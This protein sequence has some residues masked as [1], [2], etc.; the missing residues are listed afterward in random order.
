MIKNKKIIKNYNDKD[1]IISVSNSKYDLSDNKGNNKISS[2][3]SNSVMKSGFSIF[4]MFFLLFSVISINFV[5]ADLENE[6][7]IS[8]TLVNQDPDP[9]IAGEIVELRVGIEN[10]GGDKVDDLMIDLDFN[11]PFEEVAGEDYEKVAGTITGYQGN[12]NQK[13]I[14]YKVK[15]NKDTSAGIYDLKIKYY[16]KGSD[17]EFID[18]L[19]VEVGNKEN[20][21]IVS[22][23]KTIL[24]PGKPTDVKFSIKNVG[25]SPIEDV[26]FSFEDEDNVILPVGS[27]NTQ[28]IDYIAVNEVVDVEYTIVSDSNVV[29]GLYKLNLYL[30]YDDSVFGAS[31]SFTTK[32]G[33]YVGGVTDFDVSFSDS[34]AGEMSFTVANIGSNEASSVSVV[35]PDQSGWS[36]SGAKSV[37][38]GNLDKGD[39]TVA[40][41]ALSSSKVAVSAQDADGDNVKTGRRANADFELSEDAK[42]ELRNSLKESNKDSSGLKI[43]I[44]YT[45]T[46]GER[47]TVEKLVDLDVNSISSEAKI[48]GEY[49]AKPR[50][51]Q[52]SFFSQYQWYIV[53]IILLV[54]GWF[55]Y[56]KWN[57]Q[58]RIKNLKR[59]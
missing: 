22:I 49:G 38:I 58:K 4:V 42:N 11:Y 1:S 26:K 32:A 15:V 33:M 52:G 20:I 29:S 53:G 2:K 57:K 19:N 55:G 3:K 10:L 54:L 14:K 21:E 56:S 5:S 17:K 37:I 8:I 41:F 39:Y 48:S 27:D 12:D 9:A 51:N 35:I 23:D 6:G 30:T 47:K 43:N 40:S 34:S 13:I 31:R 44:V 18:T 7:A 46:M 50:M 16:E 36:V 45:D 28:F 24:L 59:K 25:N